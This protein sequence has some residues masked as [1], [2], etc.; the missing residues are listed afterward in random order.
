MSFVDERLLDD[1]ER[2][3]MKYKTLVICILTRH[4]RHPHLAKNS[5]LSA[6]VKLCLFQIVKQL[7]LPCVLKVSG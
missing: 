2:Y 1:I 5:I 6:S 7:P 3:Q 4:P